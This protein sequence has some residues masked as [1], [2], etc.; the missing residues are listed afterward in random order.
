MFTL[1]CFNTL[2][3]PHLYDNLNLVCSQTNKKLKGDKNMKKLKHI[4]SF[5]MVFALIFTS[6]PLTTFKAEAVDSAP[7]T[8]IVYGS[9]GNI[10][11]AEWL[12]DLAVVFDM[13][14]ESDAVPD[15]Y[16]SDLESS[17]PYYNDIMLTVEFGVVDVEAGG[18]IFVDDLV[19]RDFAVTTLN[20]CLG[21]QASDE[22]TYT[23]S[24]SSECSSPTDAL[25][26]V[27]HGWVELIDNKFMPELPIT[28]D[29]AKKMLDNA[30]SVLDVSDIDANYDSKY[31]FQD[32]VIVV[33]EWVN[34]VEENMTFTIENS[35]V[36][37]SQGNLFAIYENG[38]PAVY[39]AENVTND[40]NL[41]IITAK[42]NEGNDAFKEIDA[43]GQISSND[44]EFYACEDVELTLS[45]SES[46]PAM[47]KAPGLKAVKSQVKLKKDINL[48]TKVPLG[49]GLEANL[50]VNIYNPVVNYQLSRSYSYATLEGDTEISYS[51]KGDLTD[52]L[53][54]K[55]KKLF[56]CSVA[57]I[58]SFDVTVEMRFSGEI[59]GKVRGNLTAGLECVRGDRIRAIH[60]FQQKTCYFAAGAEASIGLKASLGITKLPGLQAYVFAEVG[61]KASL[62]STS[63][64]TAP[65]R[66]THFSA[67]MY[68]RFSAYA[69]VNLFGWKKSA[70][71]TI[72]VFDEKNSP[73][74]VVHHYEDGVEVPACTRGTSHTRYFTKYDSHYGG[75][76]W[77]GAN[78]S[79]GLD[80]GGN[81]ISLYQYSVNDD[82]EATIT[83]YNGNS[84]SVYIPET[85]DGY[86]VVK[87][88][89]SAFANKSIHDVSIPDSVT[90]IDSYAFNNCKYLKE[91]K[92]S[93]SLTYLGEGAFG[94]TAIA[95]IEIP[96]S[97]DNC[98]SNS[99]FYYDFNGTRTYMYGGPFTCC[100]N[101]KTI[102]FEKGTTQ[103]AENLFRG[104]T[105][106]EN[107]TIPDTV[108]EIENNAFEGCVR[109]TEVSIADNVTKIYPYAFNKCIS[110]K[111]ANLPKS[112]TYLGER[113]FGETVIEAIEIPK[114]LDS[115]GWTGGFDYD[116]D[117]T[118]VW[119]YG[120]PFY[121][122]ENLKTIT[123]EKGT[124]QIT[125][126]LFSGCTGLE[127]ITVP[128]T[129]AEIEKYAFEG[130]VRLTEVS[131]PD[132]V[133]EIGEYS[134]KSCV[135]L[136]KIIIPNTI[137]K[138]N[139]CTFENCSSL[140][141]VTIPDSVTTIDRYAFSQCVSL[142]NISI[143]DS[144]T[145]I[146]ECA[147][148][149]CSSLESVK[150]PGYIQNIAYNM[151]Q[152]CTS[153]KTV[154]FP[155]TV[156]TI[157]NAAFAGC[158]SLESFS[159][160]NGKS[161]LQTIKYNAFQDCAS[162]KEAVLPE[163]INTVENNAFRNCVSLEKV[164]IPE[165]TRTLGGYV[166]Q[167]DELL[168][169]VTISDYSITKINECT[170]KDCPALA[171]IVLPKGLTEIGNQAFMNDTALFD[172]TIP[173]SV[174]S[175]TN[176]AFSY[177]AKTIIHGKAGSYAETFA[178][179]GGFK[180]ND[181]GIAAEGISLIDGIENITLDVGETYR[182]KFEFYP[183]DANDVVTMTSDNRNVS[184]N[185]HDIKANYSGNSVITATS[186]SGIPYEFNIHTR[187]PRKITIKT[188]ANKLSYLI[189]E[190]FERTGLVAEVTY[191]DNST[192]DV[193]DFTISGFDSYAEG[194]CTV[195]LSWLSANG[196]T[197]KTTFS[198]EIVDPTPKLTGITIKSVPNKLMYER[199][200]SL[201]LTGLSVIG[202]YSDD[203]NR[204]IT[205]YTI[206]GYN[207]LK[208]G[209]QTITVSYNEKTATFTVAVKCATHT[210]NEWTTEK[211]PICTESGKKVHICSVCGLVEE[212]VIP[213][214]GHDYK[215]VV[216]EPTYTEQ[217]YTL[218][219]CSHCGDS[220][221]D[222]Y[223]EK[224]IEQL[225]NDSVLSAETIK[226]GETI[227][228]TGKATGG[229]APYQYQVVYKKSADSKWTTAQS[230]KANTTVT[231]KPAS[232]T[233]YDVCIKVKDSTGTEVK[234]FFNINV[235]S[236]LTNNSTISA[237][238]IGLGST[239]TATGKANGGT[240]PYQYQVVYK[241]S[242]DSKWT[243]AQSYKANTTV[244]FKP[245][246]AT[247]Y[248]VCIKVKDST[249]TEVKKFF[250]VKVT[251]ALKNNSVISK[252]EIS[253]GDTIT[254]S[255]KA[256]GGTSPYQYNI[257]YK[258]TAQSKW[259]TVQ[260]YK[261]NS[262]VTIKPAKATT[263]DVCVKI[264]DS[265]G[266]IVKKFFTVQ[267]NAKLANTSTISAT[268]IKKGNTV[269]VN[270]SATGGAGNYTYAVFYK[271]KA[272]TQ[273]TTKQDF[274]ENTNVSIKP[275]LA[276]DYDICVKVKD[277]NGTIAKQYFTVTVTK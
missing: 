256:T 183:E 204:E 190:E 127:T 155:S 125:N 251:D 136:P 151:F 206:S 22:D 276:T 166:F 224:L 185:G 25:I 81:S 18:N 59:K 214:T 192:K 150:L 146:Y 233:T 223:T 158:T 273:W 100:E 12:H 249:G 23:F 207:A 1:F 130:C 32:D 274:N 8:D 260:S 221:K 149:E 175:I 205:D 75:S 216:I 80:G 173:E 49:K 106:L 69:S 202:T 163:T 115:C 252:T 114:T 201:N 122:C 220:Y 141:S 85:I 38:I 258:Q 159:F 245:A 259:T 275:M 119:I 129:I 56:T 222:N 208:Y 246:S 5:V 197:Y 4:V 39:V 131:I 52:A 235:S 84:Y 187:S 156:T 199:K 99:G 40:G 15:N 110:L 193:T 210:F 42:K 72:N 181:I 47:R 264:K 126:N 142:P 98:G 116:F 266:T 20:F 93:K 178:N 177:P 212:E 194:S 67:Y 82:N 229:T 243:T 66:C 62:W 180:F 144:V 45:E 143:P 97:L 244:T 7:S 169:D 162:L 70:D 196:Y 277:K 73:I 60:V 164:Y 211:E 236:I 184:I 21:Y 79:Y 111:K 215:T 94:L 58:G 95:E 154:E 255:G 179:D 232:A 172:V 145:N 240:A 138:I 263:Y 17:H 238:S 270:G 29:E 213:A 50:T 218:H 171:S 203:S 140:A 89:N 10:T 168:K 121:H 174:T 109:L 71:Y 6:I 191:D 262:T 36:T 132:S 167:G 11:R 148:N 228:A 117:G 153:L 227:T 120:G 165:S 182:A 268:E 269:T 13:S 35:P 265:N 2:T 147:F 247:T 123:F 186:S 128:D 135:S 87:I 31:V 43:Q 219:T 14:V 272:Q 3:F 30:A 64:D 51:I 88:G 28:S 198:V 41:T 102:T 33:P 241:K 239:L 91:V 225:A 63:Y 101:L 86:T 257:L 83:K 103:I 161:N 267:V 118:S 108:T 57:G 44:M 134:F 209:K 234:K 242:T 27:E 152:N 253:L 160:Q 195:T 170:F 139:T 261:T 37:I 105:G 90:E 107:I 226:L 254:V 188:P 250:T 68:M 24:D 76:G 112:L 113:A 248:D 19:S 48:K 231:F 54:T 77:T 230:Y 137:T 176:S 157:Q 124:T 53:G 189:G 92:L 104:C 46:A 74:K 34:T 65:Y 55:S 16:F 217:G 78:G 133:T 237:T 200:E 96:K 9:N 26:A 271:Q 61:A